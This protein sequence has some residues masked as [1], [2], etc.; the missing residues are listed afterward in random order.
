MLDAHVAIILTL[1]LLNMSDKLRY[2]YEQKSM[3]SWYH[4]RNIGRQFFL[5]KRWLKA[6]YSTASFPCGLDHVTPLTK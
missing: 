4:M 3:E 6:C 5:V 2:K 1:I